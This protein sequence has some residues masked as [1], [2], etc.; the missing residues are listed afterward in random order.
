MF[1]MAD[2]FGKQKN[3]E[4]RYTKNGDKLVVFF[5]NPLRTLRLKKE[6]YRKGAKNAKEQFD[7]IDSIVESDHESSGES[8]GTVIL[9]IERGKG[10]VEALPLDEVG[11]VAERMIEIELTV[12]SCLEELKRGG[13][14]GRGSCR[15]HRDMNLQGI[16]EKTPCF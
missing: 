8:G 16:L 15:F 1:V 5:A 4:R 11:E 10:F 7:A 14:G 2:S 6:S 3:K 9:A 12:E 13:F